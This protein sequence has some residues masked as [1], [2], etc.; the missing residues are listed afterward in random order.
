MSTYACPEISL[1]K[2]SLCND[3]NRIIPHNPTLCNQVNNAGKIAQNMNSNQPNDF[4]EINIGNTSL[5]MNSQLLQKEINLIQHNNLSVDN[6][7]MIFKETIP[8]SK[9]Y[10]K[11][12][13]ETSKNVSKSNLN[14]IGGFIIKKKKTKKRKYIKNKNKKKFKKY[15][16]YRLSNKKI[17]LKKKRNYKNTKKNKK[18]Y[19][20]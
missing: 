4:K 10:T 12:A 11:Y 16:K 19:I 17:I 14:K 6:G 13:C 3:P 7:F 1:P 18:R 9:D 15:K 5:P 20:Y 8:T 2:I